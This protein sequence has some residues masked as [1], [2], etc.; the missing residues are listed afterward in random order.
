M[1]RIHFLHAADLHL[2]TPFEGIGS[3]R[4]DVAEA[5]RDA[6]LLAWDRLVGAALERRVDFV[7]LAG[8][9]YDGPIRGV[10]AQLRF[11]RGLERLSREGIGCFIAH[12]NHDPVEEG[13]SAIS[14]WPPGVH[15]FP[16]GRV[17]SI[18]VARAGRRVATVHGISFARRA[19][20][21]NLVRRFPS[22]TEGGL[23]VGVLHCNVEGQEGHDPYAPCRLDDLHGVGLHYWAL[24]HV[25]QRQVLATRPSWVA[26]PGNLQGRSLK[27]TEQGPKGALLV[28]AVGEAVEEVQ[29]LSLAPVEFATLELD[30]SGLPDLAAIEGAAFEAARRRQREG[31]V[32]QVVELRLEGATPLHRELVRFAEELRLALEDGST[33]PPFVH[34]VRVVVAT[35]P[36]RDR[37]A[38]LDRE[39]F[40]GALFRELQALRDHP[41]ALAALVRRLD[42]ALTT[43][44]LARWIEDPSPEALQNLL[45]AAESLAWELLE[46]ER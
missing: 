11:R 2:D 41:E 3:T 33:G 23:H 4:P 6:S 36:P 21:E 43:G 25:H 17:E 45:D 9:L 26:Y 35:R 10:R 19:E 22:P 15:V 27:R 42:G 40:A 44:Q 31:L 20:R 16:P 18:P 14:H 46:D 1:E 30:V 29:F 12:G 39:D 34:W 5:L 32:G 28:S 7:V 8:D 13:W 37:E 24:G 38:L